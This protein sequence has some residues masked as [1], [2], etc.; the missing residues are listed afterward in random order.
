[1]PASDS[2]LTDHATCPRPGALRARA[3]LVLF[4]LCYGLACA[5]TL[6]PKGTFTAVAHPPLAD[7]R[8]TG[9]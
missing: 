8:Q 3:G 9:P 2:T 5:V 4:L 6:A 7:L 1:M